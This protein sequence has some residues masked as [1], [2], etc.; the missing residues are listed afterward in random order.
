MQLQVIEKIWEIPYLINELDISTKINTKLK[1][2]WVTQETSGNT[3]WNKCV[4]VYAY[5]YVCS[6]RGLSLIKVMLIIVSMSSF[7]KCTIIYWSQRINATQEWTAQGT[8]G[9]L[10]VFVPSKASGVPN[11]LSPANSMSSPVFL[12]LSICLIY[13][14][15]QHVANSLMYYWIK[16]SEQWNKEIQRSIKYCVSELAVPPKLIIKPMTGWVLVVQLTQKAIQQKH[17]INIDTK[18]FAGNRFWLHISV[19]SISVEGSIVGT[20]LWSWCKP[21]NY[22]N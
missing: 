13:F 18:G 6:K 4:I 19:E 3:G 11:G 17:L 12:E 22:Q 9:E 8:Q 20:S 16:N 5:V 15:E 1:L 2:P 10:N 7:I 21:Q 14:L